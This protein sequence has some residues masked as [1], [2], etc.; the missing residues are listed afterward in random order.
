MP[1]SSHFSGST[2]HANNNSAAENSR[3]RPSGGASGSLSVGFGRPQIASNGLSRNCVQRRDSPFAEHRQ[4]PPRAPVERLVL[5]RGC[6]R[7]G[8]EQ[9]HA[10]EEESPEECVCR[11][12]RAKP[13][14]V[15]PR[16]RRPSPRPQ[17]I[18]D[19]DANDDQDSC[20]CTSATGPDR[21][22]SSAAKDT[23][24]RGCARCPPTRRIRRRR[25]A[26]ARQ[27]SP[28]RSDR[29]GPFADR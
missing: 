16:P 1:T 4:M 20:R 27:N 24:D 28:E 8:K 23:P 29:F 5:P 11:R 10:R 21:S 7:R 3:G 18:H 15:C 17:I 6:C 12:R 22:S 25:A 26:T 9:K 2:S 13:Q 19:A 14:A